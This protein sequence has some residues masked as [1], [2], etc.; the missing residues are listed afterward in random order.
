ML[1]LTVLLFSIFS[2][3]AQVTWSEPE[4]RELEPDEYEL[5]ITASMDEGWHI[6]SFDIDEGGPIPTSLTFAM[7]S[8]VERVDRLISSVQPTSYYDDIFGMEISYYEGSVTFTQRLK[9]SGTS[10]EKIGVD[11]E[12]MACNDGSCMPPTNEHFEV[13]IPRSSTPLWRIILEAV[14]WGFAALLTPCVFPMIPMTISYFIK[15]ERGTWQAALYGLF[16]VALYTLP[17]AA[18]ILITYL[19]GGDAVMV[20]IFNWIATHWLPNILFFAIFILFAA[21]FLGAFDLTLP[22]SWVNRSDKHAGRGTIG[23]IFF[24]SLTLV[25]VSF[26]CTGPIV[27]S[28]LIA[29]T[30]GEFWQPIVTIV[31][32]S[33]AFALPFVVFAIFP[34]AMKRLPKSGGWLSSVKSVLGFLELAL[35]FKFLSVAD[36]TY[37]WGILDREVYL[38][39]WIVIFS[40]LG[41][42]LLGKIRLKHDLEL[43][44]IGVLRLALSIVTFT[45]VVYMIPG[46]WGAPLRALSGYLPP[47]ES[48]DFVMS[49]V[50]ESAPK[51]IHSSSVK[52]SDILGETLPGGIKGF[53][54][55][56]E[57]REYAREVNKPLLIDF[58]GHGCVNCRAMEQNVWSDSRV[59][60]LLKNEFVVVA[61]YMDDKYQL[62]ESE[63]VTTSSGRVLKTLGRINSHLAMERY[64]VNAQPYYILEGL[65]G[66]SLAPARGYDLDVEAYIDFLNAGLQKFNELGE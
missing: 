47:L 59:D 31:A 45:F 61:L 40:M 51:S 32:F 48:Q 41:F 13:E 46:M 21:S 9:L 25:L 4:I 3:I 27:G 28:V 6:Y 10:G 29:S 37:H 22:S 16:I 55:I 64:G 50:V 52:Y 58:T 2:S 44:R 42:Y 11:V 12:W 19:L 43:P 34:S 63:W 15:G 33:A 60:S 18:I 49:R 54:D 65:N 20:D 7:P 57:A 26:S 1:L 35:A 24:L 8:G 23:G 66:E 53:Y 39:I 14:L 17:V 62:P 56:E 30:Q 38:A 5:S 36:Q